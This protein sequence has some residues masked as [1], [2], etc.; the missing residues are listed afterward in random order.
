MKRQVGSKNREIDLEVGRAC[1]SRNLAVSWN[2][3][4]GRV[5]E[6]SSEKGSNSVIKG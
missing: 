6:K 1:M 4:G 2:M 5:E 3:A